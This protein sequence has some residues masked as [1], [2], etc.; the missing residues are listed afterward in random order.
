MTKAS[1]MK[2]LITSPF[3]APM[4][5]RVP[6]SRVLSLIDI[7]IV[8]MTPKPPAIN[9]TSP[10]TVKKVDRVPV[11]VDAVPVTVVAVFAVT[12]GIVEVIRDATELTRSGLS[13]FT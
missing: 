9:A 5:L 13:V 12:P 7:S 1:V 3:V 2:I 8:L 6:I 4:A 11:R 10:I